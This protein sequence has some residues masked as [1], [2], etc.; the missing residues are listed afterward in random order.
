MATRDRLTLQV[1]WFL[2]FHLTSSH[3]CRDMQRH[4]GKYLNS[5]PV[6]SL[7][8]LLTHAKLCPFWRRLGFGFL[9][10]KNVIHNGKEA[11]CNPVS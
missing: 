3:S 11:S 1:K 6:F 5:D 9:A 7:L 2:F 4:F 8:P 10:I